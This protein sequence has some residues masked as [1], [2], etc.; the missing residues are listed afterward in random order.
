[1]FW[2]RKN[3]KAETIVTLEDV[4]PAHPEQYPAKRLRVLLQ[5]RKLRRADMKFHYPAAAFEF[6]R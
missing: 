2:T 6:S 4:K 3:E 5:A 1:M